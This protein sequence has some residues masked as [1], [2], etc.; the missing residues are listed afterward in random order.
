MPQK[1]ELYDVIIIGTGPA[2]VSASIYTSR[3]KLKTI[4]IGKPEEG[5][6]YKAHSV[7][8]YYGFDK[9][10]SGKELVER[11][12]AQTKNF[13]TTFLKGE[14]V[15]A[16]KQG[17]N[18]T[19]KMEDGTTYSGKKLVIAT[20]KAYKILGAENEEA[21]SGKGVHYCATCDGYYF[22]NKKVAIVGHSNLAAEEALG[23]LSYTKDLTIISNGM[24]FQFSP[25]LK[26]EV[27]KNKI[28]LRKEKI[29]KFVGTK[30]LEKIELENG[31]QLPFDGAFMALG[32][33]S[34]ISFASR[35]AIT[36]KDNNIVIDRD[37]KTD[38]KG[39]FAAGNCT[40][41]NAQAAN[42]V[43]EGCNAAMSVI[44]ELKGQAVY[45]DYN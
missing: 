37:G 9:A 38:V 6:L 23:M 11:A 41:G 20:G 33:V 26:K 45:I 32:R 12:L 21:L 10:P 27:E 3:A 44:K 2:G 36:S 31:K 34:A 24:E 17:D 30:K 19:V 16:T 43:G 35:L 18:F 28:K 1:G 4:L 14:V 40:G 25:F 39:V 7:A 42:S 5:A 29:K 15:N 22:Q 8:N 13:G